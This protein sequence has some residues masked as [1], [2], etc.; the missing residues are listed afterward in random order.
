MTLAPGTAVW[1]ARHET[2]LEAANPTMRYRDLLVL[3]HDAM[4]HD[5]GVV[6]D[7]AESDRF[8]ASIGDWP[9]FADTEAIPRC[10]DRA[11]SSTRTKGRSTK[12][13]RIAA[14]RRELPP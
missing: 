3:V 8:A 5:W 4:A 13:L 14:S 11:A 6:P 12:S 9:A 7:A 2:R 1:F 10:T